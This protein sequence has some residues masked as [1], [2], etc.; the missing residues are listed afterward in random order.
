MQSGVEILA[1]A[2]GYGVLVL[3]PVTTLVWLAWRSPRAADLL[4][5]LGEETLTSGGALAARLRELVV[6]P[7]PPRPLPQG[8]RVAAL[9]GCADGAA[10][11]CPYCHDDLGSGAL[12]ACEC[13]GT[14]FHE[15]CARGLERC[16]TLGCGGSAELSGP[17]V[18]LHLHPRQRAPRQVA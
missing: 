5:W 10:L 4:A 9:T 6:R 12:L 15:D 8:Y 18:E 2:L 7:K 3:A 13:C 16:T 17:L 1:M 14:T 11:R